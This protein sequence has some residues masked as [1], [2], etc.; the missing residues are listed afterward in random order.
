MGSPDPKPEAV[1]LCQNGISEAIARD[2]D[3][4]SRL[5]P[6]FEVEFEPEVNLYQ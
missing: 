2:S 5:P 6:T 1:S 4:D 3:A